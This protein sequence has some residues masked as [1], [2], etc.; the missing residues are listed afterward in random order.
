[1]AQPLGKQKLA[2]IV[3]KDFIFPFNPAKTSY[4]ADRSYIKHKYPELEGTELEDLGVNACVISGEGEFFGKDAYRNWR[5]LLKEYKKK[6]VG[7]IS[8]PI[9]TDVTRGLMVSLTANV[10]G[11][12][13]Y[14]SYTFEIVADTEPGIDE[15]LGKYVVVTSGS[16]D[17]GGGKNDSGG[18][19]SKKGEFV[20]TVVKGECLSV[21][22]ARYASKYKTTISWKKI[23]TYN[24]MKNPN[25]I[26]VGDKIK[27][28]YP[29]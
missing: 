16:P 3:Y 4:K 12:Q 19:A 17:S 21:I 18:G 15:C 26:Y 11:R 29:T 9:F 1:M 14:I 10:E 13:D 25:L 24:N 5:K 22:C 2:S 8:H 7:S 23:A 20:H 27:I 28:Y 6:D